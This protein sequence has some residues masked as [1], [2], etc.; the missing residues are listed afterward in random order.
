MNNLFY[1]YIGLKIH[2]IYISKTF[3]SR[4]SNHINES[5]TL[6]FNWLSKKWVSNFNIETCRKKFYL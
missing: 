3:K 1:K 5:F 4:N 6:D 2:D